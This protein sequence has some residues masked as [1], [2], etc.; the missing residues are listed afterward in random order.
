MATPR[1]AILPPD[2][3]ED[4]LQTP[5]R[6]TVARPAVRSQ[7]VFDFANE[8]D[9]RQFGNPRLRAMFRSDIDRAER[10]SQIQ[11][12]EREADQAEAQRAEIAAAKA[13]EKAKA[14]ADAEE[15]KRVNAANEAAFRTQGVE[16]YT[17]SYGMIQPVRHPD[18]RPRYSVG[19]DG[20][21]EL[22]QFRDPATGNHIRIKRD[23]FGS[24][25]ADDVNQYATF[26]DDPT[27][28]YRGG[29]KASKKPN[30]KTGWEKI[31]TID[32]ALNSDSPALRGA[33]EGGRKALRE[34]LTNAALSAAEQERL[35]AEMGIEAWRKRRV[36]D[37]ER[38]AQIDAEASALSEAA[39]EKGGGWLGI[40][41]SPTV[42]AEEAKKRIAALQN[43]AADL[44]SRLGEN[45]SEEA[46]IEADPAAAR[47]FNTRR[48]RENEISGF[49]RL[50]ETEG[51]D[52]FKA[53]RK[54]R[55]LL[56][57][58]ERKGHP[59]LAAFEAE[60]R[61]LG[62]QDPTELPVN[63]AKREAALSAYESSNEP[64]LK[65]VAKEAR[66]LD[67]EVRAFEANPP[68][69][70]A[71]AQQMRDALNAK[72]EA[73]NAKNEAAFTD[74]E[75]KAAEQKKAAAA[76]IA[77]KRLMEARGM[78]AGR[79]LQAFTSAEGLAMAPG[80]GVKDTLHNIGL[81]TMR[82]SD[83]AAESM[84]PLAKG[85]SYLAPNVADFTQDM[86][87]VRE[88]E[89]RTKALIKG[90][91]EPDAA[92]AAARKEVLGAIEAQAGGA[93]MTSAWAEHAA[94]LDGK[95]FGISPATHEFIASD[96]VYN[97]PQKLGILKRT[98]REKQFP[99][100]T[101][102]AAVQSALELIDERV[103]LNERQA[104]EQAQKLP[105]WEDAK[106]AAGPKATDAEVLAKWKSSAGGGEITW[107]AIRKL[108]GGGISLIEQALGAADLWARDKAN[109]V[110]EWAGTD[111]G[112][113]SPEEFAQIITNWIGQD[114]IAT[115][116]GGKANPRLD[117]V[118]SQTADTIGQQLPGWAAAYALQKV[119]GGKN[120]AGRVA[121]AQTLLMGATYGLQNAASNY[122]RI[123]DSMGGTQ[124][125]HDAAM[126]AFNESLAVGLTELAPLERVFAK[127][128]MKSMR[129]V[130]GK[131]L[132]GVGEEVAQE[133]LSTKLNNVLTAGHSGGAAPD[134]ALTPETLTAMTLGM[135]AVIAPG[136]FLKSRKQAQ[137]LT[138][139]AGAIEQSVQTAAAVQNS[140]D[141]YRTTIAPTKSAIALG[142]LSPTDPE[143][144]AAIKAVQAAQK[145]VTD[146]QSL[147]DKVAAAE[148]LHAT[149]TQHAP[150]L[151]QFVKQGETSAKLNQVA[152]EIDAINGETLASQLEDRGVAPEVARAYVTPDYVARQQNRA[153]G[154]IKLATGRQ[155]LLTKA[156]E[157]AIATDHLG[158]DIELVYDHEGSPIIEENARQGLLKM[159]PSA[160][161]LFPASEIER[162]L[163]V[164]EQKKAEETAKKAGTPAPQVSPTTP[165][166]LQAATEAPDQLDMGTPVATT[167]PAPAFNEAQTAAASDFSLWLADQGMDPASA[168]QIASEFVA[169]T[170]GMAKY[171]RGQ[172][173]TRARARLADF[174]ET[175]GWRLEGTGRFVQAGPDAAPPGEPVAPTPDAV[176]R[177]RIEDAIGED[178]TKSPVGIEYI[179]EPDNKSG[180]MV[181]SWKKN[182]VLVNPARLESELARLP[183]AKRAERIRT[184]F[185]EEVTHALQIRAA[186]ALHARHKK[187]GEN[188]DAFLERWYGD[189]WAQEFSPELQ[190]AIVELRGGKDN[191][192]PDWQ[193]ALE[194]IRMLVQ[195]RAKGTQSEAL[196]LFVKNLTAKILETLRAMLGVLRQAAEQRSGIGERVQMEISAI[197]WM[198][199]EGGKIEQDAMQ[200]A[201]ATEQTPPKQPS[202]QR[203]LKDTLEKAVAKNE[204]KKAKAKAKEE[205]APAPWDT[206]NMASAALPDT[207]QSLSSASLT[208][209][210]GFYSRL[211]RAID[212]ADFA[213]SEAK[214]P[215]HWAGVI[216]KWAKGWSS[217]GGR[218]NR[219]G[220]SQ[221][222]IKWSGIMTWLAEQKRP[223]TKDDVLDYVRGE[224]AVRFEE[225]RHDDGVDNQYLDRLVKEKYDQYVENAVFSWQAYYQRNPEEKAP[226]AEE[227][228][229]KIIEDFP[230]ESKRDELLEQIADENEHYDDPSRPNTKFKQWSLHGGTNYR[231]VVVAMP[232]RGEPKVVPHPER[233][234]GWAVQYPDG[235]FVRQTNGKPDP[236]GDITF[237]DREDYAQQYGIPSHR[238]KD[239]YTSTHFSNVPNYLA[240]YRAQDFGD[241]MLI[242]EMQSDRHQAGRKKG[243]KDH[244]AEAEM[245]QLSN[246]EIAL[247]EKMTQFRRRS[248]SGEP[249]SKQEMTEWRSAVQRASVVRDA[250]LERN[251]RGG[252][253]GIPDAPFRKTWPLMLFKRALREAVETGKNWIGWPAGSVIAKRFQ[254]SEQVDSVT[255]RRNPGG[256]WGVYASKDG[257][258]LIDTNV[259]SDEKL[260][261][262]IGK[263]LANQAI[264]DLPNPGAK[265]YSGLDLE[266]GGEGMEGFYDDIAPKMIGRYVRQWGASVEEETLDHRGNGEIPAITDEVRAALRRDDFLGFNNATEAARA[267]YTHPDFL[268]R[269][270]IESPDDARLLT[271]WR[272]SGYTKKSTPIHRIA[273]TPAM[274]E[275]VKDGLS[276][277]SAPLTPSENDG[278]VQESKI[279]SILD[280]TYEPDADDRLAARTLERAARTDQGYRRA[281]DGR[282]VTASP[283]LSGKTGQ[284][285]AAIL[286]QLSG[287]RFVTYS[288]ESDSAPKGVALETVIGVSATES[289]RA[290][291]VA[292]H[293]MW[294]WL[295]G[296]QP[297]K[298][299]RIGRLIES[300]VSESGF[301]SAVRRY[302]RDYG[303]E[304]AVQE[305]GAN[306]FA[307][308]LVTPAFWASINPSI[309]AAL[310]TLPGNAGHSEASLIAD[311]PAFVRS[312]AEIM[313]E[314]QEPRTLTAPPE[315]TTPPNQTLSSAP[316]PV[317]PENL[318][319]WAQTPLRVIGVP[320]AALNRGTVALA[321]WAG[322]QAGK[323]ADAIHLTEAAAK[324]AGAPDSKRRQFAHFVQQELLPKTLLPREAAAAILEAKS[325]IGW[326]MRVAEDLLN[327]IKKGG[328]ARFTEG[329]VVPEAG[330]DPDVQRE[331]ARYF[332]GEIPITDL[333]P[334]IHD[335]AKRITKLWDERGR[336]MVDAGI[337]SWETYSAR[338][339]KGNNYFP[340]LYVTEEM[341]NTGIRWAFN[342]LKMK[343]D[344]TKPQLS[345][346]WYIFEKNPS[347]GEAVRD[348]FGV[349]KLLNYDGKK[350]RFNSAA[351]RDAWFE[352]FLRQETVTR[353]RRQGIDFD[354]GKLDAL[355]LQSQETKALVNAIKSEL[356]A[357]YAKG[358]PTDLES[359]ERSGL[360]TNMAYVV[361]KSLAQMDH[362]V[363][364]AKLF[365]KIDANPAWTAD[366]PT[367]GYTEVPNDR[368]FG[369]LAGK[370]VENGIAQEL[371]ELH[372]APALALQ[373][374]DRA[375]STWKLWKT[376]YN[377]ATHVRNVMGN[378][379]FADLAGVGMHLAQNSSL[380]IDAWKAI[381]GTLEG[382]STQ[383][384]YE[385]GLLGGDYASAEL[386][387]I[388]RN[389]PF[390]N[391]ENDP[392]PLGTMMAAPWRAAKGV[393]NFARNMYEL[394]DAVPKVAS[395]LKARRAGMSVE[396][397]V[398][399]TRKWFPY[400]DQVGRSTFIRFTKRFTSPFLSF[401]QE[402]VRIGG[403]AMLEK[404]ITFAKWM[405]IPSLISQIARHALGLDDDDWEAIQKSMKG[406]AFGAPLFSALL[407]W[408]DGNG[409]LVQWDFSNVI[410]YADM[411]GQRN[412]RAEDKPLWS[413][414][415]E[416]YILSGPLTQLAFAWG[417]G[418]DPYTGRKFKQT[419]MTDAEA[420][421][422]Q[423]RYT[424]KLILPPLTPGIGTADPIATA[425]GPER[426][427][428]FF[429]ERSVGQE[430]SR[431]L[432]GIDVKSAEPDLRKSADA[433]REAN[434]L[435]MPPDFNDSTA[436]SRARREVFDAIIESDAER[437]AE[438]LVELRN[439]TGDTIRDPQAINRLFYYRNPAFVIQRKVDREAWMKT[440][441]PV[442]KE[443]LE[444]ST[445]FFE[446]ARRKAPQLIREAEAL[447]P[448]LRTPPPRR[449][450]TTS[451]STPLRPPTSAGRTPRQAILPA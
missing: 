210:P 358:E 129:G 355:A 144:T 316:I 244:E 390:E 153:R 240:H 398:A 115:A 407:P 169:L 130:V 435:P 373:I 198:L 297:R 64:A 426:A 170:P 226:S 252:I 185:D 233:K 190:K 209:N 51:G 45:T 383:E 309:A 106:K 125:A 308:A 199:K 48:T 189:L 101:T 378:A 436:K 163:A 289:D 310:T 114:S 220:I 363:A 386:R 450:L 444:E 364:L 77:E 40:G 43:E 241:G 120:A 14:A 75:A 225:V 206:D 161:E 180:G 65:G 231:E 168:Q 151:D 15:L 242:E 328:E 3:E 362:D 301:D 154:L 72:A 230:I 345:T 203:K 254:L 428:R 24:L 270:E 319:T 417:K 418:E 405:A 352:D 50:V 443:R 271:E 133:A 162:K 37:K 366:V 410:P 215:M 273:I 250:I 299:A 368:R 284:L 137:W 451:I 107:N 400:Y 82:T 58:S 42:Q 96:A 158:N 264:K 237:W 213:R 173:F 278:S 420:L 218:L 103:A 425:F 229:A 360:I 84:N 397:A 384:L 104:A 331:M 86:S 147:E 30:D 320:E 59:I 439:R 283:L 403:R 195:Q 440:L 9:P 367:N 128:P 315:N 243:Y 338:R 251:R 330:R 217:A 396:E 102:D 214:Q 380:Y 267:V 87:K 277:F 4:T 288:A 274:R 312:V 1:S 294:H 326:S 85:A 438:A 6:V 116:V 268:D 246:E 259:D 160:Q 416:K 156:E 248:E 235:T 149:L 100:L 39:K 167:S 113:T 31:A 89:K 33:A 13:A 431:K 221:D 60:R 91:L 186:R 145:A 56:P 236:E 350:W 66:D 448:E 385:S 341:N 108:A 371:R 359:L 399:H 205:S 342:K 340:H 395:F 5:P 83:V 304:G 313:S 303:E 27:G 260:A 261:D 20:F 150:I 70:P 296:Q 408:P 245:K 204:K 157:K 348:Q 441:S 336:A 423:L 382:T 52:V 188:F 329:F 379:F 318:G 287:P 178:L 365:N 111:I 159:V 98:I 295:K 63:P 23:A 334:A 234:E 132:Q 306:I 389:I 256:T 372:E 105:G 432:L 11:R 305:V 434:G 54:F 193:L 187:Q 78:A 238:P 281:F 298:A 249:L 257:R 291:L 300:T 38:I 324:L 411:L 176:R 16:S 228:R 164:T 177:K 118:L 196:G 146:A 141:Q 422:G 387:A 68:A 143:T 333:P 53:A 222:E 375:I 49:R 247:S 346:A 344:R 179:N 323:A 117:G 262:T 321:R 88:M 311:W 332:R 123:F 263:D 67:A 322:Q 276:L 25:H 26:Q 35:S 442:E 165:P 293:E 361:P 424:G 148:T 131:I 201:T 391:T 61:V 227:M 377:P 347:T 282:P 17:D 394:E 207:P 136:V 2:D 433:F 265:N 97:D 437:L 80:N 413:N 192:E 369:R 138:K 356:R 374:Y 409:N 392:T 239:T 122:A 62:V 135:G 232:A 406:Q 376:V 29:P 200:D 74:L 208:G 429:D 95:T 219:E 172:T 18:G 445:K 307:S 21:K 314:R 212:S 302:E 119:P 174:A 266:V 279:S 211:E 92:R 184:V 286:A 69:D 7:D 404:P 10:A 112:K 22:T 290:H 57:E 275:S 142:A 419:D 134:E 412:P 449:P 269:W 337:M 94:I 388:L 175:R 285:G 152:G 79:A 402:A 110:A 325:Q 76:A 353:V 121:M 32:E 447:K 55:E 155:D 41:K 357:R 327:T 216:Q 127:I 183:E 47:L 349:P 280:G 197:E 335:W 414:L 166:P 139:N 46:A 71:K 393:G 258:G 8:N 19:E 34:R 81:M 354:L 401:M 339:S 124:E 181:F 292:G 223:L 381:H 191:Q 370:Y 93:D 90:G 126:E 73:L 427:G 28:V 430:M 351:H 343:L 224:G 171:N 415:I 446:S 12:R 317:P 421:G 253:G 202:K 44:R 272:V 140:W 194:G 99:G 109:A 182:K 36:S 255:I